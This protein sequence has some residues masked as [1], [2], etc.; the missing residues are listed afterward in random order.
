[1]VFSQCK[2]VFSQTTE[3]L[4]ITNNIKIGE[5]INFDLYSSI[6]SSFKDSLVYFTNINITDNKFQL[7]YYNLISKKTEYYAANIK[8][9][10]LIAKD[11]IFSIEITKENLIVLGSNYLYLY[12]IKENKLV[13]EKIQHNEFNFNKIMPLGSNFLLYVNYNFHPSDA[14]KKHLWAILNNQ[15]EIKNITEM[16]E[17]NSIFSYFVNDWVDTYKDNI[18]YAKTGEYN[19]YFYN[20]DFKCIDSIKGPDFLINTPSKEILK[21]LDS[22]TKDNIYKLK[23]IDD[24]LCT[25]IRKVFYL[26]SEKVAVLIKSNLDVLY[27]HV[28]SKIN[29]EWVISLSDSSSLWYQDG[30]KYDQKNLTYSEFFQNFYGLN[31]INNNSLY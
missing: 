7:F 20:S 10:D 27:F 24:S 15:F 5:K 26:D 8:K 28:W 19:L 9:K 29:N 14:P 4:E 23:K 25:R 30:K 21:S 6:K 17:E 16:N 31:K 3:K 12:R 1:V 13:L 11:R 2:V 22:H 18:V